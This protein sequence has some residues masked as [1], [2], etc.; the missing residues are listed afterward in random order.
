MNHQI[1]VQP[2]TVR[3]V[4]T[5]VIGGEEEVTPEKSRSGLGDVGSFTI[6]KTGGILRDPR[7]PEERSPFAPIQ[8]RRGRIVHRNFRQ[9]GARAT[10]S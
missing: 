3:V 9:H 10:F 7:S 2:R 5:K 8:V 6:Q 1:V 4:A